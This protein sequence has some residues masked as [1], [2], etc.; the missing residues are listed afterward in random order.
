MT[1]QIVVMIA[2]RFFASVAA[3]FVVSVS[4]FLG[5]H[6]LVGDPC[7]REGK[8]PHNFYEKCYHF[9]HLD[10][11]LYQQYLNYIDNV[12]HGLI[13]PELAARAMITIQVGSTALIFALAAGIAVG[14]FSGSRQ[15][16]LGGQ[17]TNSGSLVAMGIP[18]FLIAWTMIVVG[19][20]LLGDWT[21]GAFFYSR[22]WGRLDQLLLPALALGVAPAGYVARLTRVGVVETLR[23]EYVTTA[24]AKGLPERLILRRHILRNS[25][26]PVVSVLGSIMLATLGGSIIIENVFLVPGL[27]TAIVQ[28]ILFRN[29]EWAVLVATYYTL[30]VAVANTASDLM[31]AALDPRTRTWRRPGYRLRAR[32]LRS[33]R[34]LPPRPPTQSNPLRSSPRRG[35][36]KAPLPH[37]DRAH[38]PGPLTR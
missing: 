11:P 24:R 10:E 7:L 21:G 3:A 37:T 14:L 32:W 25:L 13:S 1:A 20:N 34:L 30:L 2:R 6:A 9:L 36:L 28:G 4:V 33:V 22:G 18:N 38:G 17:I 26:I 35:H 29:Y 23:Q 27:G 31:L 5:T 19:T 16:K 15:Q 8:Q 12:R